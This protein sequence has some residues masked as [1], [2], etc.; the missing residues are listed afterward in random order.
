MYKHSTTVKASIF[1]P[2]NI[3]KILFSLWFAAGLVCFICS[4]LYWSKLEEKFVYAARS[5]YCESVC[6]LVCSDQYSIQFTLS[7]TQHGPG[8]EAWNGF[9]AKDHDL[10]A[11]TQNLKPL[12]FSGMTTCMHDEKR[13]GLHSIGASHDPIISTPVI[14][15]ALIHRCFYICAC[16]GAAVTL[17]LL[18]CRFC[19]IGFLQEGG[20][21]LKPTMN[22]WTSKFPVV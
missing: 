8:S 1:F 12:Y 15:S 14:S 2:L 5:K 19:L 18:V 10:T 4:P 6:F 21:S 9:L 3:V 13:S 16:C 22:L 20:S 17:P 7:L 11:Q